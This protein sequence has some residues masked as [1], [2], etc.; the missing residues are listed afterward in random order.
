MTDLRQ[1][2]SRHA[3]GFWPVQAAADADV[4]TAQLIVLKFRPM[5]QRLPLK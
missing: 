5:F 3:A 1:F 4:K 2:C